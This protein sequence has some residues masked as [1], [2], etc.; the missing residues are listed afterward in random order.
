MH[1]IMIRKARHSERSDE[2]AE[3]K[4]LRITNSAKQFFGA[5]ILRLAMLAQDDS[6]ILITFHRKVGDYAIR[7]DT[8][9]RVSDKKQIILQTDT[10]GGVSLYF[11]SCP[12]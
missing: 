5:K 10:P 9:P 3:S 12:R 1:F 2:G 8:R 11:L 4:N 7:R 6:P